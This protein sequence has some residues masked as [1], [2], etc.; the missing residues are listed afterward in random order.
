MQ[1][2]LIG[3]SFG[4]HG[5]FGPTSFKAKFQCE[6]CDEDFDKLADAMSHR[7]MVHSI[8]TE[9]P[10]P[11]EPPK[12]RVRLSMAQKKIVLDLVQDS[13]EDL[14]TQMGQNVERNSILNLT[15]E[16]EQNSILNLTPE[17]EQNSIRD[18][19]PKRGQAIKK[20]LSLNST[21]KMERVKK[22]SILNLA[23]R[24]EQTVNTKSN[25]NLTPK[26]ERTVKKKSDL[27]L[28]P[29]MGQ[30]VKK[31]K[32]NLNLAPRMEQTVVEQNSIL[33]LTP[34]ASLN[35]RQDNENVVQALYHNTK[36]AFYIYLV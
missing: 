19:T 29:K 9:E 18:S 1:K 8:E 4:T 14:P 6:R 3:P 20:K 21:P 24:M 7:Y 5:M 25:L 22:K 17:M 34:T 35:L 36:E 23:P 31:K 16:M 30:A 13:D 28:T 2:G 26:M 32:S 15:P 27:N 11:P 33:N 12:K 10:L